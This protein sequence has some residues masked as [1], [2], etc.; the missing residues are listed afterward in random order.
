MSIRSGYESIRN[1]IE[2]E[3]EAEVTEQ[4]SLLDRVKQFDYRS[5]YHKHSLSAIAVSCILFFVFLLIGLATFLPIIEHK[6]PKIIFHSPV[7]P[8][9]SSSSLHQ[10]LSKCR[11]FNQA[12]TMGTNQVRSFNP[13][14]PK[15]IQST[16]LK[17]AVVWDGQGDIL[18]N[19][20]ILM[21]NGIITQ[22][23]QNIQAPA[24]S[25]IIDVG[26]H[27]VSPGLV[28]MHTHLGVGSWPYLNGNNDVNEVTTP[29]TPFVRA[30]DAFNPSDKG[31]RIVA[32]GGITTALV[33]PG[34]SNLIGG[35]AY[36]FK[37]R[38]VKT[39]SNEDMLVQ[40]GIDSSIEQP[41]RYMK[42]ACGENAKNN[43][44]RRHTMPSTRL[45]EAYVFR[46]SFTDAQALIREQSDWC[47]AAE[48]LVQF[49]S[50]E[51][52]NLDI[53]F[54]Q[55]LRLESLTALLRGNVKLNIHCYET[56]DIEAMV[57]H[58]NEFNFNI[59]AFHHALEAYKIPSILKRAKNNI[60]IA[61]F[62]DH[63]GYK[64][65]AFGA[66][67]HA[68]KLLFD[69]GIPVALKSDHP[70]LNSQHMAFEAAKATHY[71][72]PAQE[73]FKAITSVPA[74]ALGLGHRVGSLKEG[75]DADVV[76]WDRSPLELGATPLQVF[77]DGVP[78][79][80]EKSISPVKK[81]ADRKKSAS[82][83]KT[84]QDLPTPGTKNFVLTNIGGNLI[85]ENKKSIF[86]SEGRIVCSG[87]DCVNTMTDYETID[88]QGGYIL[89]GLIAVGSKLGLVEIPSETSTG[90]GVAPASS[91]MQANTI[92]EAFDGLKVG[93]KKL[94]EARKGGVLTTISA[95][96]SQNIVMGVS[97]AFKTGAES[98]LDDGVIISPGVALHFQIGNSVKSSSFPTISSQIAFLRQVF[99]DNIQ[100]DNRYGQAARGEI[101]IV[102]MVNNKDE[103][104]SLIILKEKYIPKARLAIMGGAE[105]HLLAAQLAQANIAVILRPHL[106]T[107]ANF[108]SSHC[109]T[110]APLTNGTAAHILHHYGVKIGLGVL[111]DGW[112][113]NLAWDAGWLSATSPSEEY[114]I[115]E[116][117]AI[118]FVTTNL[119]E[120]FG[121]KGEDDDMYVSGQEF[122]VWSGS[123]MDMESRPVFVHTKE[124]GIQY[125]V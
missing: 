27:I 73:A 98:I 57:R 13:R 80:D 41:W 88:V 93:G 54:P 47:T 117:D 33:L 62:A 4:V 94:E 92:L 87:E 69:A 84:M 18:P 121:L 55:D 76:I 75:Y 21:T 72:L 90:D 16:L 68:P 67:P 37:L 24:G 77:I 32:S 70:V 83:V 1:P 104:A 5:Y 71:G 103:I 6:T 85:D 40:T 116:I 56:H 99:T 19:V 111:N 100:C 34:S 89:P 115:S 46:Q 101:P 44:G 31:I 123:P 66:S 74:D 8:G 2:T 109:L 11:E 97:V 25:K 107:P 29:A 58:A 119:Q 64:K 78:L 9:I 124:Q 22:V 38:P 50:V 122:V 95:P 106:C 86:V 49:G 36:A 10:G 81:E 43:Y 53:P 28:D 7:S 60:T 51:E 118:K 65:E 114:A 59:S 17:N 108:D 15:D 91:S 125:L 3:A 102:I 120:I 23:K 20:D 52:Q 63:W 112:A 39:L 35:E 110:G 96:L 14:A 105:A 45:G 79:F 12:Q 26:G 82:F 30:I 42:M 61:T 113:R 48:K